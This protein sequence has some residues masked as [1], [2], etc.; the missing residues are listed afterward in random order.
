MD[1]SEAT[2][3]MMASFLDPFY[4]GIGSKVIILLFTITINI[5]YNMH[6]G[7]TQHSGLFSENLHLNAWTRR[8]PTLVVVMSYIPLCWYHCTV[9]LQIKNLFL[10]RK[11]LTHSDRNLS[12]YRI[13]L[14]YFRYSSIMTF[15]GRLIPYYILCMR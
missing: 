1:R 5:Q 12:N 11:K 4:T 15:S 8:E 7:L 9:S 6:C 2:K 10:H 3:Q 14:Q 13:F